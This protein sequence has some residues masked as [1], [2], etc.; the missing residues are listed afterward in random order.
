MKKQAQEIWRNKNNCQGHRVTIVI[1]RVCMCMYT[2][3]MGQTK[4]L[5]PA[6]GPLAFVSFRQI[7]APQL[8]MIFFLEETSSHH[9]K[10]L[11]FVVSWSNYQNKPKPNHNRRV[12]QHISNT[13]IVPYK[14]MKSNKIIP[15]RHNHITHS[16]DWSENLLLTEDTPSKSKVRWAKYSKHEYEGSHTNRCDTQNRPIT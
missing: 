9:L 13:I 3:F 8:H 6:S 15:C 16:S 2:C 14:I 11:H 1:L 5:R 4:Q 12:Q 7:P 10:N